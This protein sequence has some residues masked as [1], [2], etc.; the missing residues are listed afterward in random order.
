MDFRDSPEEAAFR[1]EVRDWLEAHLDR[2]NMRA[3]LSIGAEEERVEVLRDWQRKLHEGGWAGV[4]WPKEFGGRG[5]SL[6]EQAIFYQEMARSKAPQPI[7]VLGLGMAGPTIIVH[8]TPEQKSAYLE[9]ILSADEIWCQGFSEP[10]AGS[11][12]AG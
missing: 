2:D 4:S 10:G 3:Q 12:L 1:K 5:A 9:K 11:D 6:I 8:G 7:N